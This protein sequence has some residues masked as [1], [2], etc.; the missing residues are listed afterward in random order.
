MANMSLPE[1]CGIWKFPSGGESQFTQ[2]GYNPIVIFSN[3]A[4]AGVSGLRLLN[5][6][7][8]TRCLGW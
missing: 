1:V 2:L 5:A 8:G 3:D 7:C 6:D 4:G